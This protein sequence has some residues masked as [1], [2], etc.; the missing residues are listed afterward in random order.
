MILEG[1]IAKHRGTEKVEEV[2]DSDGGIH[3]FRGLSVF[4]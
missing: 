2:T 1:K 3:D 4:K